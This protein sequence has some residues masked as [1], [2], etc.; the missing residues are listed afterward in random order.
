MLTSIPGTSVNGHRELRLPNTSNL[1]FDGVAAEGLLAGLDAEGVC[2]S[3]G[4]ACTT[5][6]VE[7]SHVLRAMGL[8]RERALGSVR[9]SFS[10]FNTRAEVDQVLALLPG[11]VER[12]RAA[13]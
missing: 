5:G 4:S 9:F 7:P 2:A 11:L 1:A 10:R 6:S 13:G 3:A 8:S 12:L